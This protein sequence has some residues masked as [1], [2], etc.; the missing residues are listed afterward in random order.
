[1][2]CSVPLFIFVSFPYNFLS[3]F[4][5]SPMIIFIS[6][7]EIAHVGKYETELTEKGIEFEL[8]TRQLGDVDRCLCDGVTEGFVKIIVR[9]G[10]F[11][12]FSLIFSVHYR[13][14]YVAFFTLPFIIFP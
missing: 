4:F 11:Q 9:S 7:P 10:E 8:Y 5:L 14:F 3:S 12:I 6:E 13:V 2:K 1:M